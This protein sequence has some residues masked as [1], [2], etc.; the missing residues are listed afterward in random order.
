M[1]R[2]GMAFRN[3]N[4]ALPGSATDSAELAEEDEPHGKRESLVRYRLGQFGMAGEVVLHLRNE[5]NALSGELQ[6]DAG[7]GEELGGRFRDLWGPAPLGEPNDPES[8]TWPHFDQPPVHRNL[9]IEV[10]SENLGAVAH[11]SRFSRRRAGVVDPSQTDVDQPT[12]CHTKRQSG[13]GAVG[14]RR[15]VTGQRANL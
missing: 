5:R 7:R 10:G 14:I 12:G 8:D 13:A 3:L 4:A 1:T 6:R 2:I 11:G 15:S 9:H